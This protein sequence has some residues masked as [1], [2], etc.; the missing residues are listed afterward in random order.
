MIAAAMLEE[1]RA[2]SPENTSILLRR[3]FNNDT[4]L[5]LTLQERPLMAIVL[6]EQGADGDTP[7]ARGVLLIQF[8][9]QFNLV[10]AMKALK[11]NRC[12]INSKWRWNRSSL[13]NY[14]CLR[15]PKHGG[16]VNS[17]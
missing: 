16:R 9:A 11:E 1:A 13:I 2:Q 12:N 5:H 7:D 8:V 10:S 4:A 6:L 14:H 3:R 17:A 15:E